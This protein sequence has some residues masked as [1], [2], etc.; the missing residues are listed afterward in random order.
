[1][2]NDYTTRVQKVGHSLAIIVPIELARSIQIQ[3]G[4]AVIFGRID[5]NTLAFRKMPDLFYQDLK[6]Q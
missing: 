4:D 3:R 2:R 1:M 6:P 5:D